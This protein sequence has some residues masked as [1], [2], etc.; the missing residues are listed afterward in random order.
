MK[1][2]IICTEQR[3]GKNN[4]FVRYTPIKH[5]ITFFEAIKLWFNQD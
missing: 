3:Y 4:N 5:T 1:K 2:L